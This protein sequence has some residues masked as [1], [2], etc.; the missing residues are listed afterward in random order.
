[1]DRRNTEQRGTASNRD[2]CSSLV[3][4]VGTM[5]KVR[6]KGDSAERETHAFS[7]QVVMWRA[8]HPCEDPSKGTRL[9]RKYFKVSLMI[10]RL[11]TLLSV[12]RFRIHASYR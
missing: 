7:A 4:Y 12:I 6:R 1:M 8:E 3:V 2:E 5:S 11:F 9:A 10:C